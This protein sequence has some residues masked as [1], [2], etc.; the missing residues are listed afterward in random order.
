M[1]SDPNLKH[2]AQRWVGWTLARLF[3]GGLLFFEG[4]GLVIGIGAVLFGW[5][6]ARALPT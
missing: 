4:H 1:M 5:G 2:D 6:L 3:V